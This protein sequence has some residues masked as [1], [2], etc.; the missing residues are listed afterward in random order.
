MAPASSIAPLGGQR[1][2]ELFVPFL[3]NRIRSKW[4]IPGASCVTPMDKS[5]K[6]VEYGSEA[7]RTKS[8]WST[9]TTPAD[10]KPPQGQDLTE[11]LLRS[12][13]QQEIFGGTETQD[14]DDVAVRLETDPHEV[15]R[16]EGVKFIRVSFLSS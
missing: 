1:F 4:N 11:P 10:P 2:P 15:D 13:V 16:G 6:E 5:S 14:E 12:Q 3:R 7:V 9:M 8:F